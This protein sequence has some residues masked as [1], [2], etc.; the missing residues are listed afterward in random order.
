M[1]T[2]TR[3]LW[4]LRFVCRSLDALVKRSPDVGD[5]ACTVAW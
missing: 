4:R 5:A 2:G 3:D 1:L